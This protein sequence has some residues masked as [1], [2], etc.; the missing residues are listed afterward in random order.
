MTGRKKLWYIA[1][2]M[3]S[4]CWGFAPVIESI[5]KDYS[6]HLDVELVLGGLRP[7]TKLPLSN[8]QKNEILHHWHAVHRITK[9]P[10]KFAGAMPDG[11]IYDTEMASRAIIT[12]TTINP[13]VTFPFLMLIQQAFY[14]NQQDVTK[15]EVLLQLASDIK[16]NIQHFMQL[17]ESDAVKNKTQKNF[18]Q[19]HHWGIN[20]FPSLVAENSFSM[21]LLTNGY[22]SKEKLISQLDLWLTAS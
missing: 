3:C 8:Q 10:F 9:Q 13:A 16:L 11:F 18:Q 22:S 12:A 5:R 6:D 4:W 15:L 1:D 7:G 17:F 19:A 2:P 20:G 21:T 14:V